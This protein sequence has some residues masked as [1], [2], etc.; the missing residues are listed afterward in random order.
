MS[1]TATK[2]AVRTAEGAIA[3]TDLSG[4]TEFCAV[5]GD[6]AALEL[7]STSPAPEMPASMDP[8]IVVAFRA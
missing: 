7:I 3:F 5:R 8:L 4:F 6:E 1:P 2:T